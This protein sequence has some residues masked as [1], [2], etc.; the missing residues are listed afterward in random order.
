MDKILDIAAEHIWTLSI[1]NSPDYVMA[2]D[3]ELRNAATGVLGIRLY[4]P[5]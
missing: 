1:C 5:W 2:V 4:R 3:K